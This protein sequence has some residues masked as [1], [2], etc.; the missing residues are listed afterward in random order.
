[1]TKD[2]FSVVGSMTIAELSN[3]FLRT[4]GCALRVYKGK[5]LADGRMTINALNRRVTEKVNKNAG[6]LKIKATEKIGDVEYKFKAH[7]GLTVQVADRH[8]SKLLPNNVTLGEGSR[9]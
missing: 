8:N 3:K 7:F 9:M 6:E 1:M 4:F 5:Q 2:S